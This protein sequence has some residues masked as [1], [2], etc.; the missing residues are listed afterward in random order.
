MEKKDQIVGKNN[1]DATNDMKLIVTRKRKS[2]NRSMYYRMLALIKM[3][4]F[5][6]SLYDIGSEIKITYLF[7]QRPILQGIRN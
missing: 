1:T 7:I 6:K 4:Y 2:G 5:F 3:D